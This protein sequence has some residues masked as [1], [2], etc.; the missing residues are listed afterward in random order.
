MKKTCSATCSNPPDHSTV[1]TV[2]MMPACQV[3]RQLASLF[4]EGQ[5]AALVHTRPDIV[6]LNPCSRAKDGVLIPSAALLESVERMLRQIEVGDGMRDP[7]GMIASLSCLVHTRAT[8]T[9]G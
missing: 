2:L 7:H 1:L 3:T 4:A 9:V 8:L 5:H 6:V